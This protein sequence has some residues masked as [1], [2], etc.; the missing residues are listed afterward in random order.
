MATPQ[1]PSPARVP[2]PGSDRAPLPN[3][4]DLGPVEPSTNVEVSVIV[5]PR[6]APPAVT[7][8]GQLPH[9][10]QPLSRAAY[11]ASYGASDADLTRVE[12]FASSVGLQVLERSAARRT[13]RLAGTAQAMNAAFGVNLRRFEVGGQAFRGRVGPILVPTDLGEIVQAVLG[14]DDRP[15]ARAHFR[16]RPPIP[17]KPLAATVSYTPPEV[18]RLYAFPTGVNGRGQAVAMIELGGGYRD[19]QLAAY[20]AGLGIQPAP[21]VTSVGVDGATNSPGGDDDGEVQLDI[22]ICGAVAPGAHIVVYF[23]PNTDSGFLDAV[24]TA[25]HDTTYQPSVVSL[26]WGSQEETWTEQ[27]RQALDDAFQAAVALGVTVCVASGDDGS[28]DGA[29]DGKA[30]VDFP[31]S[32][33]NVLAC[34][35]TALHGSDGKIAS[36][37][38]WND[39][40]EGGAS[41]GGVSTAFPLPSWQ[42]G[43]HVPPSANPGGRVGRGV[44]DVS[45]NADPS[46]GYQVSIDGTH[47]VVGGTSAVAPLWAGLIALLNEPLG[48]PLGFVNLVL[49]QRLANTSAMRDVTTGNNG[50]YHAAAGWDACTGLGSPDGTAMATQLTPP[51]GT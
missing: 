38:V 12:Q 8:E 45:G 32:S 21:S 33:P 19:A 31:A 5:R 40:R 34:G 6:T 26:S 49:Y 15:A 25:I 13:V 37:S 22:E 10:R 46:T 36:E 17:S 18:A 28:S 27:S 41:G 24:T 44:P 11:A 16:R 20:F 7:Q 1:P 9:E 43:A 3:A 51:P 42:S 23:A 50:V 48:H 2:L 39:G 29:T 30:H 47:T 35:G 4:R 14:L